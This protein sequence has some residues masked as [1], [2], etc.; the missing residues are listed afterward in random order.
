MLPTRLLSQAPRNLDTAAESGSFHSCSPPAS[1]PGSQA[2]Q[3]L[4]FTGF[5][6]ITLSGRLGSGRLFLSPLYF[7]L[8]FLYVR[9]IF[10]N[11]TVSFK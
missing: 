5:L 2:L 9:K 1:S 7:K 8:R 10:Y 6:A 4:G 11:E 3:S